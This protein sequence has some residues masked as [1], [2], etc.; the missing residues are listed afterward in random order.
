MLK[1]L[2]GHDEIGKMALTKLQRMKLQDE[3][4]KLLY[5]LHHAAVYMSIARGQ[6]RNKK[7]FDVQKCRD[8]YNKVG[9]K[10]D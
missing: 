2:P 9:D 5:G 1:Q 7:L 8:F 4:L 6:G 3:F 10:S